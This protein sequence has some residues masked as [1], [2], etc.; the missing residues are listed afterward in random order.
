M[1]TLNGI[2]TTLYGRRYLT[3]KDLHNM[4]ID[5]EG[6]VPYIATM[7]FVFLFVP[8]IP[9]SSYIV[10]AESEESGFFVHSSKQ[11]HMIKINMNWNQVFKGWAI[12]IGIIFILWLL[13]SW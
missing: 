1:Y 5:V 8:I 4:G 3:K 2:G 7:W 10:F 6:G 13:F 12:T 9:L 11:Y